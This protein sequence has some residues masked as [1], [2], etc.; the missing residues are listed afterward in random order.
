MVHGNDVV[1]KAL[2]DWRTSDL[3]KPLKAVLPFIEKV[4]L[5][6]EQVTAADAKAVLQ[7]G[8][9]RQMIEDAL[10][11]CAMFN[12][13]NRMAD[14]FNFEVGPPSAFVASAKALLRFGYR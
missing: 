9:T 13:I 14:A 11:I 6:P 5:T 4:T 8:V 7:A 12:T 10:F 2:A 1:D 3:G